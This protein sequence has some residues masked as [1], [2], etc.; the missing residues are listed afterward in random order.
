MPTDPAQWGST[1]SPGADLTVPGSTEKLGGWQVGKPRRQYMN[2]W[3]QAVYRWIAWLVGMEGEDFSW[4]GD[5]TFATI[6]VTGAAILGT[7]VL[8]DLTVNGAAVFPAAGTV[9]FQGQ[10]DFTGA[11]SVHPIAGGITV[12][13]LITGNG[14]I[15]VGGAN[16]DAADK[17]LNP[18]LICRGWIRLS[19]DAA[20]VPTK[21]AG[22]NIGGPL[23][24]GGGAF[25]VDC[26][27][28]LGTSVSVQCTS[29]AAGSAYQYDVRITGVSVVGG[30]TRIAGC[31]IDVATGLAVTPPVLGETGCYI[32]VK[33]AS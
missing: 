27:R 15:Q 5:H 22:R 4:S 2:W 16:A 26:D 1:L 6:T 25:T 12:G 24:G 14:G 3:M 33:S 29:W 13:G 20:S 11:G 18:G 9:D 32:E 21:Q 17:R 30:K 23:S 31:S 7:L 28:D 19:F 8:D 10:V